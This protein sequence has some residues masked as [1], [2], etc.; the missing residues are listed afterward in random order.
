MSSSHHSPQ[1]QQPYVQPGEPLN[2]FLRSFWQRQIDAAEQETPDYRHPPLPLAR[3]KKVM[4][5]DP[6]VKPPYYSAKHAKVRPVLRV[7]LR[8]LD[9]FCYAT[10]AVFIA[11]ITA[12]AFIV[13]DSNKR[14]TLSRADIAKALS[15][16][17]QFDFLIDIVPR[18]EANFGHSMN[19]GS[20][21]SGAAGSS[22]GTALGVAGTAKKVGG[23][24]T[25]KDH[26]GSKR[27]DSDI[28]GSDSTLRS[29][30]ALEELDA[31]LGNRPSP[32]RGALS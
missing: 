28:R 32:Q 17:D 25:G 11:E 20:G 13:A 16:S 10:L 7:Y 12:R 8:T 29:S 18:D 22:S 4:K 24:S 31:L 27:E 1:Q 6:D 3:I 14:R 21:S 30:E 9:P 19:G 5:S 2:D 15:K 23:P 26:S